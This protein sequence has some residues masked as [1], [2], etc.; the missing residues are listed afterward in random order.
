MFD[1]SGEMEP[2][3]REEVPTDMKQGKEKSYFSETMSLLDISHYTENKHISDD[4]KY[5]LIHNRHPPKGFKFPARQ[6]KDRHK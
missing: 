2:M 4:T 6:S 3:E 1:V 5:V